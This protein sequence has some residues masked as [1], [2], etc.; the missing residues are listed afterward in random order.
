[1]DTSLLKEDVRVNSKSP[2]I[3][4]IDKSFTPVTSTGFCRSLQGEKKKLNQVTAC[5]Y[6]YMLR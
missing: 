6:F 3:V 5:H 4:T 1:M 2:S